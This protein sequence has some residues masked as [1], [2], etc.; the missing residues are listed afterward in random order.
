MVKQLTAIIEKEDDGFVA[1]CPE[2]D[3]AS[4][5]DTVGEARDNVKDDVNQRF[6]L[7]PPGQEEIVTA[8]E[9][10]GK[11]F[12]A[13]VVCTDRRNTVTVNVAQGQAPVA[14]PR[15]TTKVKVEQLVAN[16]SRW[17]REKLLL[18]R[19]LQPSKPDVMRRW[20][21][22]MRAMRPASGFLRDQ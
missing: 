17:I 21:G 8:E 10:Q 6:W 22:N 1:I 19:E 12:H 20:G 15:S 14:A 5:G 16:K 2:F 9:V 7:A 4:Q 11:K 3:V 13:K 18:Q